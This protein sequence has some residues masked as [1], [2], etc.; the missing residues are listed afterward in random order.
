MAEGGD[1]KTAREEERRGEER[2]T[3]GKSG[4]D[5]AFPRLF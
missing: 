1:E 3:M 2:S 5:D 4:D